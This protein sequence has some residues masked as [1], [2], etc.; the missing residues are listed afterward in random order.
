MFISNL[1][2]KI[3]ERVAFPRKLLHRLGAP[4]VN[5]AH[6]CM[7]AQI[8][9]PH[10]VAKRLNSNMDDVASCFGLVDYTIS[11]I[12]HRPQFDFGP[13]FNGRHRI[14]R[15]KR[16]PPKTTLKDRSNSRRQRLHVSFIS[17]CARSANAMKPTH[18]DHIARMNPPHAPLLIE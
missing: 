10:H 2:Q 15:N 9:P 7:F 4:Q 8:D 13:G 3:Q 14:R 1:S 17:N 18:L 16:R 11:R 12:F 5:L 6:N